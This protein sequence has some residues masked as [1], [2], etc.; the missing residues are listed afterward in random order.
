[1]RPSDQSSA[2]PAVA[3]Q[4]RRA[5]QQGPGWL[6]Y[7]PLHQGTAPAQYEVD[8]PGGGMALGW[9]RTAF[10]HRVLGDYV[11]FDAHWHGAGPQSLSGTVTFVYLVPRASSTVAT[12][13]P[14]LVRQSGQL[15]P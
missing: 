13:V 10:T 1:M 8:V 7:C 4:V 14:L 11:R 5:Q 12:P 6:D 9:C 15:P 3:Q 2:Q